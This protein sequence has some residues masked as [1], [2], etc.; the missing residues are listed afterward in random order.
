MSKIYAF[1]KQGYIIDGKRQFLISGEIPYFRVP[2]KDWKRRLQLLKETG[3]NCVSTYVPWCIHEQKEGDI[4]FGDCEE[5]D[6]PAFLELARHMGLKVFLRP[7]PYQY[8]E[9]IGNGIPLWLYTAY[10]E[11]RAIKEDGSEFDLPT[12]S[13]L[14]PTLLEKT[15]RYFQ[16][17]CN[18]VRPYLATNDGP[19]VC[20]QL[21]NELAGVHLW[22]GSPDYN[23]QS[24]G[25]G[26]EDG[27][28]PNFLQ[29][30]YGNIEKLN[31]VYHTDYHCFKE[32]LPTINEKES[33]L[34]LRIRRD[35]FSF[36]RDSL[37]EFALI[38]KGYLRDEGITEPVCVNAA[39]PGMVSLFSDTNRV[40]GKDT[41]LG[42]DSYFI[43]TYGSG[44]L[45]PTPKYMA[46]N[47]M[48]GADLLE[49]LG[50]PYTV[51]EMQAGTYTD[52][53]PV[54]P[55]A[56][57]LFYMT[58]LAMGLKGL[59]YYI[60]SGGKNSGDFG[61]T[62]AIYD[63]Q[64]CV[65]AYGKKRPNYR[66][67]Q[68]FSTLMKDNPWLVEADRVSSVQ[69]GVDMNILH[70]D[71]I[72]NAPDRGYRAKLVDCPIYTLIA[73]KYTVCYSEL[74]HQ[75]ISI[76]KPLVLYVSTTLSRQAQ[77]N[78]IDFVNRGGRLLIL[79]GIAKK[80]ENNEPYT[81]L[82]NLIGIQTAK[83]DTLSPTTRMNGMTVY[84]I[85]CSQK[86][87]SYQPSD[88]PLIFDGTEKNV[89]GI[90]GRRGNGSFIYFGG[91]WRMAKFEQSE[92][93]E[94]ILDKFGAEP[95]LSCS[96]R[97]VD[98]SVRRGKDKTAIFLLNFFAER[99][100]TTVTLFE[101]GRPITLGTYSVE[102]MTVKM[103][104]F[105]NSELSERF[106]ETF[107]STE[108]L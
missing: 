38:L 54:T 17:F 79:G 34:A 98:Y 12:F 51:L 107:N 23:P 20:L 85:G 77:Q 41:L 44:Q 100:N 57:E 94:Q 25:F 66:V 2:K 81:E 72:P 59:N 21:D 89:L 5:R 15:K 80:D 93:L 28:Y 55:R 50:N 53:P 75:P 74:S 95:V 19:V 87:I 52:I 82:A 39:S 91:S 1:D 84:N 22:G 101:N 18:I 43:L 65:N 29:K 102:P 69:I 86:I 61:F 83:N 99:E 64:A 73:S 11:T 6:L 48:F 30:K 96:N 9:L 76:D 36:Y 3:A 108:K 26:K 40:L 35:Y 97:R 105:S 47:I 90:E 88:L 104:V 33:N 103:L 13:Y 16:A 7:G 42:L 67:I 78:V 31:A 4:R 49:Q 92:F 71:H 56:L 63:Y 46:E 24:M 62:S 37:N 27:R 45:A 60:F 70:N 14:H 32:V 58:H 106:C 8:S 68:R 10:P